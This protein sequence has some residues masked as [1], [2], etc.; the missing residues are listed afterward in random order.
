M[1][2]TFK[3]RIALYYM[4]A[5]AIVVAVLY[6]VLYFTV[7]G[8]VYQNIDSTLSYEANK[9]TKEIKFVGDTIYFINK[10][11]WEEREHRE[12]QVNPVF[13]QILNDNGRLMD[14]SPNLK[15]QQLP[16][17]QSRFGEHFDTRLNNRAI[18]Q[19]QLPVRHNGA[20]RGYILA[21]VSLEPAREI[22]RDLNSILQISYPMVLIGLFFISRFL[23]GRS[24]IPVRRITDTSR[25][26]TQ[27]NLKERVPLPANE[28]ELYD[29]ADS[30]N[31]L[32]ERIENAMQRERQFTSDA[33]HELRTPLSSL[34]GTLE[35]L[36]RKPRTQTEYEEK[37]RY[38]LTE[39]DRMTG[40]LEQLL[41][42]A[43]FYDT[44]KPNPE[45]Q[46]ALIALIDEILSRQTP[47]IE[48]KKLKIKFDAPAEDTIVPRYYANL[49]LDNVIN[50]AIKYSDPQ[51]EIHIHIIKSGDNVICKVEDQGI[52][53][54][55]ED[56]TH[57]FNPFFRSGALDH[58]HISGT[59]LG[60]SIAQKAAEAINAELSVDSELQKGT[61]VTIKFNRQ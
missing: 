34:R 60:L 17:Y 53:I 22:L 41:L 29:M 37:I 14:K 61:T 50:N 56:I 13:I 39:I 6:A 2:T 55:Q 20:T 49:I 48:Q 21:A 15:E 28:D 12:A 9:H 4:I 10:A 33:S 8:T 40:I 16:F 42:L 46:V 45:D 52:G 54:K 36:I 47:A 5:T 57:L 23:A 43:R 51:K 18:R 26:I 3:N 30:I 44:R 19:V 58:K 1:K 59:G 35:V 7:K 24:I 31:A 25:R 38:S 27:N 11:E 32:L